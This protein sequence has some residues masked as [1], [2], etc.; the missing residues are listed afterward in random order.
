MPKRA[1]NLLADIVL[2]P[3]TVLAFSAGKTRQDLDTD[4]L[5]RSAIER[6]LLIVGEAIRQL[7]DVDLKLVI[8]MSEYKRIIDFRNV[9]AHGYD[10][11][12]VDIVWQVVNDK[13]P[14]LLGEA[15]AMQAARFGQS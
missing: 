12:S 8:Q 4:L 7:R 3:E 11:V 15:R 5:L 1:D 10:V 13:L 9:L 2:A 14:V 6:Q